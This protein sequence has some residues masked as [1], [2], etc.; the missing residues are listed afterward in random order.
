MD[1]SSLAPLVAGFAPK[2]GGLLGT[3]AF[4]P[5]GG[6]AGTIAGNAIAGALGV[7]PTPAA[8]ADKIQSDPAAQARI[9]KL[10]AEHADALISQAQVQIAALEQ[11]GLTARAN[12]DQIGQTMRAEVGTV[13]WWHWRNLIGYLVILYGL[14]QVA[15]LTI[16]GFFP[17]L[18]TPADATSLFNA[19]AI[20]TGGLF[21]LLGYVAS[22][23]TDR[24][25]TA[26]TGDRGP[27]G[28]VA[29]IK[30]AV[31]GGRKPA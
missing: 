6:I 19:T 7:A 29:T 20:F 15:M 23:T 10:E 25:K 17:K 31:T 30:N 14:Q 16:A 5:I 26:I 13:S 21:A 27:A 24:Y 1:W 28:L 18:L 11:A 22:D 12:S 9:E 3:A 8:V 4:G 2:L